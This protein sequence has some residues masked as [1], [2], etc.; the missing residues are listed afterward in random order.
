MMKKALSVLLTILLVLTSLTIPTTAAT[1]DITDIGATVEEVVTGNSNT[2]ALAAIKELQKKDWY[3]IGSN[4]GS[5]QCYGFA[6]NVF[7]S[8]FGKSM[9]TQASATKIDTSTMIE[10]GRLLGT[11]SNADVKSLLLK[12]YPGDVIQYSS[13]T[14]SIHAAVI[15]EVTNSGITLYHAYGGSTQGYWS[16]HV[17][18]I[19]WAKVPTNFIGSF[20]KSTHGIALY[21][22]KNY[23]EKFGSSTT[24]YTISYNANGGTGSI[25]SSTVSANGKVDV[26]ANAFSRDGYTFGGYTLNRKS[27]NKWFVPQVGWVTSG[28]IK[29][30]GYNYSIYQ[31]NTSMTLDSSWTSG[32]SANDTFT[33]YADW[34]P[35][36]SI[37]RFAENYSEGNYLLGSD[38]ASDYSDYIYSR[39]TSVYTLSVDSQNTYNNQNSLKI[40]GSTAGSSGNDLGMITST[41]EG[42]GDTYTASGLA[43]DCK[44]MVMSFYAKSSVDGAR[45]YIRWG[46]N[47]KNAYKSVTLTTEWKQYTVSIPKNNHLGSNIH[48]YFD[49]A[50]TFYLNSISVTD[51]TSS[52]DGKPETGRWACSNTTITRGNAIDSLPQPKRNGFKFL[53]W[54][55]SAT[56]GTLITE[57][58]P[59][60]AQNITLYAHWSLDVVD[61]GTNFYAAIVPTSAS[62]SVA[63]TVS[64]NNVELADLDYSDAQKWYFERQSDCSYEIKN[65]Y[66]NTCMDVANYGTSNGTNIQVVVDSDN[67]AQRFYFVN[68]EDGYFIVP[69]FNQTAALD[70]AAGYMVAGNNIQS[71][72]RYVSV[73]QRFTISKLGQYSSP[74]SNVWLEKNQYW[75]DIQDTIE[76]TPHADDAEYFWLSVYKDNE[77]IVDRAINCNY[78]LSASTWGYGDYGAYISAVN[79]KGSIDSEWINFTVVGKPSYNSITASSE[80]YDLSD[81]VEITVDTVVAKGQLIGIEKEGFGRVLTETCDNAFTISASHLGTGIFHSYFTVYNGSGSIDTEWITFTIVDTPTYTDIYTD[82]AEYSIND[83]IIITVLSSFAKGHWIGIDKDGIGRVITEQTDSTYSIPASEL[84]LGKYYVYFTVYNNSG[85]IDTERITF[86]II[87]NSKLILGDADGDGE[88]SILDATIIQRCLANYTVNDPDIVRRCGDADEDGELTILDVTLIQRYLANYTVGHPIGQSI[89]G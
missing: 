34:I 88:V 4:I 80:W 86:K 59:I 72:D 52:S 79:D 50:G 3:K 31:P 39:N 21:H 56:G 9:G 65:A 14:T 7:Q 33:F 66:T 28:N 62:N 76:L 10:V 19:T 74:P 35:N 38:L 32:A 51:G 47:T 22:S 18:Y 71:W 53:G 36:T 58:T 67:D 16:V 81:T 5:T 87:D 46:F 20:T 54:Y 69:K 1:T 26:K 83:N 85:A 13:T 82:K 70:I 25:A 17:D 23:D 15:Q 37:V 49:K 42:F 77:H 43:G 24:T 45:F 68:N 30:N 41:N 12:A 73:N 2:N 84:G 44:E 75:Y 29:D 57:S 8:L 78:S 63:V 55:T 40:V 11:V 89:T 60:N 27:D 6:K 61:L 48:P 64:G